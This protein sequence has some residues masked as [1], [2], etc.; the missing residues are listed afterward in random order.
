[1]DNFFRFIKQNLA[2]WASWCIQYFTDVIYTCELTFLARIKSRLQG[3][4][5]GAIL[6]AVATR[7]GGTAEIKKCLSSGALSPITKREGY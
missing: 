7:I 5:I 3:C 6:P 1:M 2:C 4:E